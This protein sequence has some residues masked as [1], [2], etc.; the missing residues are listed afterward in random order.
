VVVLLDVG[1]SMRLPLRERM[2]AGDRNRLREADELQHTRFAAAVAAV[3][4][5][6]QQKVGRDL[7]AI[8]AWPM[9]N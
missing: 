8:I 5:V 1:A 4:N 9:G 2:A 7:S 6:I 3:E